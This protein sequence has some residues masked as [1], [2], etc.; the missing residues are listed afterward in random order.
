MF[1]EIPFSVSLSLKEIYD[2]IK[3]LLGGK[4]ENKKKIDDLWATTQNTI[5]IHQKLKYTL[6][7]LL[8]NPKNKIIIISGVGGYGKTTAIHTIFDKFENE[9]TKIIYDRR[10]QNDWIR[11]KSEDFYYNDSEFVVIDNFRELKQEELN[12]IE[13]SIKNKRIVLI[14]RESHVSTLNEYTTH[15]NVNDFGFKWVENDVEEKILKVLPSFLKVPLYYNLLSNFTYNTEDVIKYI[16]DH[17]KNEHQHEFIIGLLDIVFSNL[18]DESKNLLTIFAMVVSDSIYYTPHLEYLLREI[19]LETYESN[20]KNILNELNKV[21]E[22]YPV[23]TN[24]NIKSK[25]FH[26]VFSDYFIEKSMLNENNSE[27]YNGLYFQSVI[28]NINWKLEAG[29][30]QPF[31]KKVEYISYARNI[32]NNCF[33]SIEEIINCAED[34]R[35]VKNFLN[36]LNSYSYIY[37]KTFNQVDEILFLQRLQDAI[38]SS[39]EKDDIQNRWKEHFG[40]D[41]YYYSK[42]Q[43]FTVSSKVA[44]C[45]AVNG[46]SFSIENY[47]TAFNLCEK[48]KLAINELKDTRKRNIREDVYFYTKAMILYK[49]ALFFDRFDCFN[50]DNIQINSKKDILKLSY[51]YIT[52]S[53]KKAILDIKKCYNEYFDCNSDD[54]FSYNISKYNEIIDEIK[55]SKEMGSYLSTLELKCIIKSQLVRINSNE[56][57]K[58]KELF[59]FTSNGFYNVDGRASQNDKMRFREVLLMQLLFEKNE[60]AKN[61]L[62]ELLQCDI[63]RVENFEDRRFM[64]LKALAFKYADINA[65]ESRKDFNLGDWMYLNQQGTINKIDLWNT[66]FKLLIT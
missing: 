63:T 24:K 14:C 50:C 60:E 61:E 31:H 65:N 2:I 5:I 53:E 7:G 22:Q 46:N 1:A 25:Y 37:L 13:A 39:L 57:R 40:E 29:I 48:S 36:F 52:D 19:D 51:N 30:S 49:G 27:F 15:L 11:I 64:F 18:P 62:T 20:N 59:R 42:A 10:N 56:E 58:L 12:D 16:N 38:I 47:K 9:N 17:S 34:I 54:F 4:K 66:F 23:F 43:F 41:D 6:G 26:S 33:N 32:I 35:L 21:L 3:D 28:A 55:T 45:L 8:L 44:L